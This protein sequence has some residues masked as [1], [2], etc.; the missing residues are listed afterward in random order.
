MREREG[1]RNRKER[2]G[3]DERGMQIERQTEKKKLKLTQK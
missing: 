2:S 1:E 3:E